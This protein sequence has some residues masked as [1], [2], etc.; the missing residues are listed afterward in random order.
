LE[1]RGRKTGKLYRITILAFRKE[2]VI[3]LA[4]TYG[5]DVDWLKNVR[6]D[7]GCTLRLRRKRLRLGPVRDISSSLG[8]SR[9]P[10]IVQ[11]ILPLS[12]TREFV[13]LPI[14]SESPDRA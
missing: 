2:Q 10:A 3:T 8:M 6:A 5:P 7:G 4:L 9:M 12:G 11:M 14:L 13:E 1:H